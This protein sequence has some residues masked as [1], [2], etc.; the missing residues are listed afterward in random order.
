MFL[1]AIPVLHFFTE[2]PE[3]FY[4]SIEEEKPNEKNKDVKSD[5][6]DD[7]LFIS[8]GPVH[9]SDKELSTAFIRYIPLLPHS[10]HL[11]LLSPPPD[12]S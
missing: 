1:Q 7:K 12:F 11:E 8:P 4:T 9:F 6:F 2:R 10:P 3:I 5:K